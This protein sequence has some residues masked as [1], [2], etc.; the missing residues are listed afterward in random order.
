MLIALRDK[1][2]SSLNRLLKAEA[3][4]HEI[5]L[6]FAIGTFTEL[7]PAFGIKTLLSLGAAATIKSV[8]RVALFAALAIWNSLFVI[9]IYGLSFALG[10]RL[11]QLP[12]CAGVLDPFDASLDCFIRIF[13]PSTILVGMAIA[14]TTYL[15]LR[16]LLAR[17][18][19]SEKEQ[20]GA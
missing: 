20:P 7:L 2:V 14:C 16:I 1:L 4:P 9:P 8:N 17:Y 5:A 18:Q 12:G 10:T 13:L 19:R 3:T 6:G 11:F 15:L